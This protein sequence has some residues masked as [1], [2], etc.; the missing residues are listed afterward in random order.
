[1]EVFVGIGGSPYV[2]GPQPQVRQLVFV[3]PIPRY[4]LEQGPQLRV[5][6]GTQ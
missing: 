5:A 3:E 2:K 6:R 4:E 1:M